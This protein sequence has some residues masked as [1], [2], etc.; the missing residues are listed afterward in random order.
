MYTLVQVL[1]TLSFHFPFT[2]QI[3]AP[4]NLER[5]TIKLM[6]ISIFVTEMITT[7]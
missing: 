1:T 4:D 3:F 6:P 2:F 7:S 5:F